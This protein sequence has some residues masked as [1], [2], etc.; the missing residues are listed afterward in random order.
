MRQARVEDNPR[1]H[2]ADAAIDRVARWAGDHE[3]VR[4]LI[5]TSTRAIHGAVVDAYSDYDVVG[6]V[7]VVRAMFEDTKWQ[8]HF[9]EVLISY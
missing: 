2:T 6:V 4:T 7:D 5:L 3:N 8:D 9:G 1:V